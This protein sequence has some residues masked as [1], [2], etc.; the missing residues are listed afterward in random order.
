MRNEKKAAKNSRPKMRVNHNVLNVFFTHSANGGIIDMYPPYA[1][2]NVPTIVRVTPITSDLISSFT[3]MRAFSKFSLRILSDSSFDNGGPVTPLRDEISASLLE[4][5]L[6]VVNLIVYN[7]P[8][9]E[10]IAPELAKRFMSPR[11]CP[12]VKLNRDKNINK[13]IDVLAPNTFK[14]K[15]LNF[16]IFHPFGSI[17]RCCSS[18]RMIRLIHA[19]TEASPSWAKACFIPSS[20]PGST[21][22]AICLLPLPLISMV[23]IWLTPDYFEVVVKC[24]TGAYR[25][26]TPRT[27]GAVPRRLTKPLN[28]VTIM[29]DMQSTQTH[30]EFTWRF[31]ALARAELNGEIYRLSVDSTTEQEARR[32]LAPHFILSLAA[33]LPVRGNHA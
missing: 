6:R 17:P 15:L 26:A 16:F 28:E 14:N 18:L 23:D 21:R 8:K 11:A 2:I 25:K 19:D 32:V 1:H 22:N 33:R 30:P 24:M 13:N 5:F 10:I 20:K 4:S 3:S 29:A 27:V 31:F 9:T 7:N 12:N